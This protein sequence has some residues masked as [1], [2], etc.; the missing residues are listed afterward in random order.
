MMREHN[1]R[2]TRKL[3]ETVTLIMLA[4]GFLMPQG[5]ASES[6]SNVQQSSSV[7]LG[8]FGEITVASVAGKA[9]THTPLSN[10][11]QNQS[12]QY[13]AIVVVGRSGELVI[14]PSNMS[15]RETADIPGENETSGEYRAL[16]PALER[17]YE[18]VC[19]NGILEFPEQC[20]DGNTDNGDGCS[21]TCINESLEDA[22][23]II[24]TIPIAIA[25]QASQPISITFNN[26]GSTNWTYPSHYLQALD[27]APFFG[28]SQVSLNVGEIIEPTQN[29]DFTF[30]I[31]APAANGT[32]LI[33]YRMSNTGNLFGELFQKNVTVTGICNVTST[34]CIGPPDGVCAVSEG[35][36]CQDCHQ[37]RDGC[38]E[39]FACDLPSQTC[40]AVWGP[41]INITSPL[42]G[43]TVDNVI[44]VTF[45][46]DSR[47]NPSTAQISIDQ[48]NWTQTTASNYSTWD[49]T[50]VSAGIHTI[51][52]RAY[53]DLEGYYAH[54]NLVI[55]YV[56]SN[57][58]I[59]DPTPPTNLTVWDDGEWT[60]DRYKLHARWYAFDR[61]SK[62]FYQYRI[63]QNDSGLT[64][65]FPSDCSFVDAP[66]F[67]QAEEVTVEDGKPINGTYNASLDLDGDEIYY[68]EVRA[69]NSYLVASNTSMSDGITTDF[70]LPGAPDIDGGPP[71]DEWINYSNPFYE[72]SL[73]DSLGSGLFGFSYVLTTNANETPDMIP[74]GNP[75]N[76]T[77]EVN[78][79]FTQ[80]P[81]GIYYFK[82][83]G[84][85]NA[86][87]WGPSRTYITKID[88]EPPGPPQ[89]QQQS[90]YIN[91][92][93]LPLEWIHAKDGSGSG[94]ETYEIQACPDENCTI[95]IVGRNETG[96]S[97]ITNLS[98]LIEENLYFV[99][100]RAY[101]FVGHVGA[102]SNT[103]L[104]GI[105]EKPPV[106]TITKPSGNVITSQI[107][108]TVETDEVAVCKLGAP[109]NQNF[110]FTNTYYHEI[111]LTIGA[112]PTTIPVSCRDI[113]YN[114]AINSTVV[115]LRPL[116]LSSVSVTAPNV[117]AGQ[118]A[119]I[120]A[121]V[122]PPLGEIAKERWSVSLNGETLREFTLRDNTGGEYQLLI[123]AP[124][125]PGTYLVSVHVDNVTGSEN[126]TVSSLG[127]SV[128]LDGA[129]PVSGR[130]LTVQ[131]SNATIGI[132][133]DSGAVT[134]GTDSVVADSADGYTYIFATKPG[135]NPEQRER[136]LDTQ[137]F[138]KLFN[139]SFGYDIQREI[140]KIVPELAY[141]DIIIE[142]AE[143]LP[144]GRY[145]VILKNKGVRDG[146]TVIEVE[147]A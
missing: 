97:N 142:G 28:V 88:T 70:I 94:I 38:Q 4:I 15:V 11:F 3:Y 143:R 65:V 73:I 119:I 63:I 59:L 22:D 113:V 62:V 112:G 20:D 136:Y 108:L 30:T 7:V 49:T 81:D 145:N 123:D 146:K 103:V 12:G 52:V 140:Y 18:S 133:S 23:Y 117:F 129:T 45:D 118:T 100:I 111:A 57:T 139:P 134:V 72:W 78:H 13:D 2:G 130:I 41:S 93:S 6:I 128:S 116:S 99:R 53:N 55:V 125:T 106:I 14:D 104:G 110:D 122:D 95:G 132:G 85:D 80:V 86:G 25:C 21:Y 75:G 71:D 144:P 68:F 17:G 90:Y 5:M 10:A 138:N 124:I 114:N 98:G 96:S 67:G 60:N 126:L 91:S 54:S 43:A 102:W 83:R 89:L 42:N 34:A 29:K 115:N 16:L 84:R 74:E 19:G 127:F 56:R 9:Q 26:N 131:N 66:N 105:D 44:N 87:N 58:G 61:E 40:R 107:L 135:A 8:I 39:G 109:F 46:I 64:C 1:A 31:T 137:E 76:F 121:D 101:D 24:D 32:Y 33:G 120:S 69:L 35:C 141:E 36:N 92:S 27:Q 77:S 82:V 147:I 47:L 51:M 48:F 37:R 50:T 79:T